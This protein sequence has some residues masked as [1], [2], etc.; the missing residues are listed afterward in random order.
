[1]SNI[2]PK[3]AD[4]AAQINTEH[5]GVEAAVRASLGHARKAGELLLQ[6]RG[7]CPHGAWLPWLKDNV[8]CSART[9][10][11]YMRIAKEWE[12]LGANTQPV[13]YLGLKEALQLLAEPVEEKPETDAKVAKVLGLISTLR[14]LYSMLSDQEREEAKTRIG[15]H[16]L[17]N[18]QA[19]WQRLDN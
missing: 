8:R 16:S 14:N 19:S 15:E 1:M 5:A 12:R 2:V 7:Q 4:L 10:Q 18:L 6:A 17:N 9:V 3:L 11:G 13:A